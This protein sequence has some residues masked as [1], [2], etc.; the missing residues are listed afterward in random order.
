MRKLI[1]GEFFH[2]GGSGLFFTDFL[3]LILDI[4]YQVHY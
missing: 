2:N 1:N 4:H 3:E